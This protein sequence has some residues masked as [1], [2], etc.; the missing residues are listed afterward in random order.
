ME[1]AE[2][3]SRALYIK[4]LRELANFLE[5]REDAVLPVG[6]AMHA[7][8]SDGEV[9]KRGVKAIGLMG[10]KHFDDW[11]NYIVDFGAIRYVLY[12]PRE[13]VCKRIVKGT[14]NVPEQVVPAHV[15]EIV[16][17]ECEPWFANGAN[18]DTENGDSKR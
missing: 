12:T 7:Y 9:F 3:E 17:W 11:A 4:A 8:T 5:S 2:K 6:D 16:E 13:A 15:K 10:R 14:E 18:Q 1:Q